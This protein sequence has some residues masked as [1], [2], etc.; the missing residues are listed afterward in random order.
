ML[1]VEC[2]TFSLIWLND[3]RYS[4]VTC[5]TSNSTLLCM[6]QDR[7]DRYEFYWHGPAEVDK[8]KMVALTFCLI[9][10]SGYG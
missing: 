6:A 1:T 4:S 5:Q 9:E 10:V 7:V 8:H 3:V 2:A